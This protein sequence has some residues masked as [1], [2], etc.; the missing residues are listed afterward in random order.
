[1]AAKSPAAVA[2]KRPVLSVSARKIKD[3][4]A[5]WHNLM[6]KWETLNNNGFTIAN[7][8]VNLKIGTQFKENMLE[9]ECDNISSDCE[10]LSPDYNE[11]LEMLC[12][13]LVGT[14]ENMAKI[15]LKMEKLCST[16]KGICDLE[17]YHYENGGDRTPLFHTWPTMYFSAGC[18]AKSCYSPLCLFSG[19]HT[20]RV[21]QSSTDTKKEGAI[22][23][24]C[25]LHVNYKMK[26]LSSSLKCTRKN[27]NL[28][29][30]LCK[31]LLILLTRI[32]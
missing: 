7:K 31:R 21:V 27:Y 10:K 2:P 30:Q 3:N 26:F 19:K 6:M 18:P 1:M 12:S 23:Y 9:I 13:G 5:D 25:E 29:K 22:K 15:H 24:V 16:T 17:S 11:E 8:I 28:S 4:A 14:L 32:S 20:Y